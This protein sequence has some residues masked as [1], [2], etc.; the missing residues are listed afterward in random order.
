MSIVAYL[1]ADNTARAALVEDIQA[2]LRLSNSDGIAAAG[3][4]LIQENQSS[5][6]DLKDSDIAASRVRGKEERVV[7][8][9]R[10]RALR[11]KGIVHTPSTPAF[12]IEGLLRDHR[13]IGVLNEFGDLVFVGIIRH[14]KKRFC[15]SG[16][17]V[18]EHG[19]EQASNP[20]RD[21]R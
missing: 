1:E 21:R 6:N 5:L 20:N 12:R 10:E 19:W 15:S 18:G 3:G 7:S 8:A 2:I 14:D 9:Q 4:L 13:P 17:R 16:L 11:F